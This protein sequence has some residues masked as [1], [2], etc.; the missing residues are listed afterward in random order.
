MRAAFAIALSA[1]VLTLAAP[2]DARRADP[3]PTAGRIAGET[4]TCAPGFTNSGLTIAGPHSVMVAPTGRRRWIAPVTD[5]PALRDDDVLIVEHL[6][7]GSDY[8]R[9]DRIRALQRGSIIPGPYCRLGA[10]TS[11]DKPR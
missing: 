4:K 8:C 9:D 11:W 7:G 5:C 6:A 2:L 10:F 1:G 3:D